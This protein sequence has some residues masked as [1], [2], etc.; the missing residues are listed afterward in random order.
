MQI[1][2]HALLIDPQFQA[3]I[4]PLTAEERSG[5]EK[6]ILEEGVRDPIVVWGD[7]IV[8]GHNRY[9]IATQQGIDFKTT[10]R[11]FASRDEAKQWML[12]NQ[13]HRRNLPPRS[14]IKV[15]EQLRE[16]IAGDAEERMLAGKADPR[17]PVAEGS[18]ERKTDAKVGAL[19][20]VSRETVRRNKKVEEFGD[21]RILAD[22]DTNETDITTAYHLMQVGEKFP[23]TYSLLWEDNDVAPLVRKSGPQLKHLLKMP[24]DETAA[25]LVELVESGGAKSVIEAH[26]VREK[27]RQ[28]AERRKRNEDAARKREE[29]R[30]ELEASGFYVP[31]IRLGDFRAQVVTEPID[32]IITDPPYHKEH[33]GLWQGLAEFA[34]R[35]LRDGGVLV[36][37]SGQ[38]YLPE[39]YAAL[40]EHLTYVWTISYNLRGG[41]VTVYPRKVQTGWKPVL[42]Y[43][44]GEKYDGRPYVDYVYPTGSDK[45]FH[46]WGQD[47]GGFATLIERYTNPGDLVCDP[48]LGGGTTAAAAYDLKRR[49]LGMEID[50]EAYHKS[51]ERLAA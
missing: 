44:K 35:N 29:R 34:A 12:E 4:P 21:Q 46:E 5:L 43:V 27:E 47:E 51:V 39:V 10:P 31:D 42:L 28:T 50:E 17:Q 2:E 37:M 15:A 7:T 8:D 3:L 48:F 6:S 49:F 19:A 30:G 26:E 40:S 38:S 22:L 23:E 16:L 24:D 20:K 1:E 9:E 45:R 33:L 11:E 41:N 36:A 25:D 14:R 13:L 18:D 32:A